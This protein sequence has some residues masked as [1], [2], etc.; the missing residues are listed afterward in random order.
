MS[1][2]KKVVLI[3]G[4]V[5]LVCLIGAGIII[6]ANFGRGSGKSFFSLFNSASVQIDES[7]ELDLSGVETINVECVSGKITIAPGEPD[8]HLTGSV[9][10]SYPKD[11]YLSVA[12]DGSTLTVKFDSNVN[13]PQTISA[14]VALSVTLPEDVLTNLK[15][16]GASADVDMNGLALKDVR[17]DSASGATTVTDCSGGAL[18]INVASGSIQAEDVGFESLDADCISGSVNVKNTTG[19]V[20]I[21]STSGTVRVTNALGVVSISSTSGSTF[22]TQEQ[23]D[24]SAIHVDVISGGVEVR[25]NPDAAFDLSAQSTSGGF[26]TDFDVTVSGSASKN[27]IGSDVSGKVNGGGAAVD[28]STISGG[29]RVNKISE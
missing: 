20:N 13:F 25:L 16:S 4:S 27:F 15:V 18:N 19:S 5:L 17:I 29:I 28:L 24:L 26:S 11:E 3:V 8:A 6:G 7:A 12:K 1:T 21:S 10:T 9:L 23:K 14:N 22:V 2:T